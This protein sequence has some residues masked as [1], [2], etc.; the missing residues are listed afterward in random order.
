MRRRAFC[1]ITR[2]GR[3]GPEL[4]VFRHDDP[5]AG[6]QTPGGTIEPHETTLE[7][8]RREAIE[9]TGLTNFVEA[10][11][12]A[13]DTSTIPSAPVE[14]HHVHLTLDG[15][16]LDTWTH[17]VSAGDADTGLLFHF[18]WLTFSAAKSQVLPSMITR[19]D[20]I[21]DRTAGAPHVQSIS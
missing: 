6:I 1:Y 3:H 7:G 15:A 14:R 13:I 5:D 17:R 2:I 16:A 12:I 19:L 4:L 20:E 21:T 18:F 8:A 10:H 9:E 11:L